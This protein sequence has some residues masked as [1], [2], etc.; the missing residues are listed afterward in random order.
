MKS[1]LV[2]D[3]PARP[4]PVTVTWAVAAAALPP[5]RY[6]TLIVQL[7]PGLTTAP[8]TQEPPVIENVAA[9]GPLT[10]AI[11][12]AAVIVSGP[13]LAPVAVLLT[14]M[15]PVFVFVLAGVVV[16]LGLGAANPTV[17]P[18]TANDTP[19]VVPLFAVGALTVMA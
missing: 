13:A 19:L 12:G 16:K 17:A 6:C 2:A 4:E 14:V 18:V 8:D 9:L 11:V 5:G 10:L 7:P 3:A 1:A 15:V